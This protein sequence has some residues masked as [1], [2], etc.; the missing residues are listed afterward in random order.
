MKTKLLTGLSVAAFS[1]MMLSSCKKED[2]QL[3]NI[4]A[5]RNDASQAQTVDYADINAAMVFEDRV[6]GVDYLIT[7]DIQINAAVTVKPGVTFMFKDGAG[8]TVTENGS[9]KAIGTDGNEVYFTSESGKRGGWKGITFLSN[10]GNVLS[11]CKIEHGGGANNFGSANVMIGVEGNSAVAEVSNSTITASKTDGIFM[12]ERSNVLHFAGNNVTTNTA[13]PLT[14]HVSQAGQLDNGN[15]YT[16]NGK[17]DVR[18]YGGNS[19]ITTPVDINNTGVSYLV[20]GLV[21]ASNAINI[22]PGVRLNMDNNAQIIVSGAQASFNAVGNSAQP[23][24]IS[25]PYA[26]T[27]VWNNIQFDAASSG[28]NHIEYC[29]I[30]GGGLGNAAGMISVVNG[31]SVTVRNSTIANSAANGIYIQ[32]STS[33]Y[34][35]DIATANTFTNNADGNVAIN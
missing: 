20:T 29:N 8:F 33:H 5:Y 2:E 27:G 34:N 17:P 16:N 3:N 7:K 22:K 28:N 6:N 15:V 11:Y 21:K 9:L 19:S 35:N 30:S 18:L 1:L 4:S 12:A 31:S 24:I 23:I 32:A 26:A 10:S 25:S 14:I 13:H